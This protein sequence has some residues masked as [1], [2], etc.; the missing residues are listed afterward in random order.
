MNYDFDTIIDR[1]SSD[2]TKWRKF[3]QDVIPMWVADM[4]FISPQPVIEALQ[5]RVVHGVFG[6]LDPGLSEFRQ[7][8]VERLAALYRWEVQPE[9]LVINP[10]VITGFNMACQA[11][12]KPGSGILLQTPAYHPFL[13]APENAN[14]F[15][16]DVELLQNDDGH[17]SIDWEAL[18]KAITR[19][20]S[21][22]ISCNPHNPVGRVFREDEL[23]RMAEMCLRRGLV[24]CSDEI[25]CDLVYPGQ[26][27]IPIASLAPEIA[28]QT[29][30]LMAPSKTFNLA[31]LKFSVA[32]IQNA[33][34]RRK[35]Q[36]VGS[37]LV[38]GINLLGPVAALAA[39]RD[40]G[41]WLEQ[42]L[43]YLG[44][45]RDY[46]YDFVTN[47]LPGVS[48]VSPE[49][50]YL[51]WLDCREAG[52]EGNPCEFFLEVARVGFNDGAI[53]GMDG[54]GFV[55]LNFGCPRGI[56]REALERM[57]H[58]LKTR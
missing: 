10:G 3:D 20:T 31:G 43:V 15:R 23:E 19:Q 12:G 39:Y 35:F 37:D 42:L 58:A 47:E 48:M 54:Q 34:L 46:L 50:T 55:R 1:R 9:D 4:D 40:G 13:R 33:E 45:N 18:E 32:I 25:H 56:L 36:R 2:S 21:L 14:R 22:F 16:Q 30:T 52:I 44:A 57:R 26:R 41:D 6:Y 11:V 53:F 27:H 24:I 17:Y 29:I 38:G 51:A 28:A 49:G 8:F 5:E 7:V